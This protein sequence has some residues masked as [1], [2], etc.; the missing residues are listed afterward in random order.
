M[1]DAATACQLCAGVPGTQV[2]AAALRQKLHQIVHTNY[3]AQL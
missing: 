2:A 1:P 3:P